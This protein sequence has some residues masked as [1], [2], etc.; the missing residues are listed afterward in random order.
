MH[1]FGM[2]N[3]KSINMPAG[4]GTKLVKVLNDCDDDIDQYM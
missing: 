2:E 3:A 4:V 1:K